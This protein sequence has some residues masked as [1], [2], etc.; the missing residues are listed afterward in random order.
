MKRAVLSLSLLLVTFGVLGFFAPVTRADSIDTIKAQ[1]ATIN[2]ERAKLDAEIAGYKKELNA[3]A[4]TKQTLQT[5][6]QTLD[7]SRSKTAAQIK[8]LQKKIAGANLKLDQLSLEITN[9]EQSI[10]L[11]QEAIA[12]SIRVIDSMDDT[13][14]IEHLL[15]ADDFTEA[16]TAVDNL[17]T[18]NQSLRAHTDALLDAKVVLSTQHK[19]VAETKNELS[20]AT[21]DLQTQKN[22]LDINR[23]GKQQLLSQTQATESSYQALIA[24]R[25]KKQREFDALLFSYEAVLKQALDP[26]S[27]ASAQT[28]VLLY[29]LDSVRVTQ[30]FGKTVDAKRLYVSGSHGGVDFG[31]AEGTPVKAALAGTVTDTEAIK[32]K[33]GCQYGKFV[34]IK[35][36]NGLSTI[37]GHLSQVSVTP[38]QTI[39]TGQVVGYSGNTGYSTGPHLHFGVYATQ[40]IKIVTADALGS[41]YCAGIKT[42]AANPEAYLDPMLYL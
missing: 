9:K 21:V 29:P 32:T 10:S 13:Y 14:L 15:G 38:G 19:S 1:I 8:D 39:S 34:L 37:Y 2:E 41:T 23:Q 27:F 17:A 25:E 40:G 5:T 3:L 35:H 28:G 11:D 12:S 36:A 18:L 42:V 22:A 30:Y 4:G 31:A 7:V 33:S 26:S 24:D 16:W 20:S 6:I